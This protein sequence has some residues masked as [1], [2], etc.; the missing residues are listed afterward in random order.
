M[1]HSE[2]TR[3]DLIAGLN[4]ALA[5]EYAAVIRY[6]TFASTARG[7][8]RLTLRPLFER[9]VHDELRHAGRLADAV[10]ALDGTPTV[11]PAPVAVA[12]GPLDMLRH[13]LDAESDAIARYVQRRRQAEVLGEHGLAIAIDAIIEDESRHRDELRLVLSGYSS[14]VAPAP[15]RAAAALDADSSEWRAME[16]RLDGVGDASMDSFPASDAPPWSGMR[17]GPPR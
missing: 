3:V 11:V 10:V 2:P 7:I 8:H 5:H 4:E 12:A 6:R 1:R 17:A 14:P 15:V 9:E 13:A 16:R